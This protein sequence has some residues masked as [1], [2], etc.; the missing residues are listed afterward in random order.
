MHAHAAR[1]LGEELTQVGR[2]V[3]F[4][5]ELELLIPLIPD[6]GGLPSSSEAI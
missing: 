5:K 6:D 3:L 2:R 4:E 1:L